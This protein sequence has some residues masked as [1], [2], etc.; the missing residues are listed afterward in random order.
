MNLHTDM[1][2]G[3]GD[4]IICDQFL[5]EIRVSFFIHNIVE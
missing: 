5:I 2:Q 1:P 4:V 3:N